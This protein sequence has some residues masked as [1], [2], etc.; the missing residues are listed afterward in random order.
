[1][2]LH[3][4]SS[5]AW[6]RSPT[7]WRGKFTLLPAPL[8]Q[9]HTYGDLTDWFATAPSEE[10]CPASDWRTAACR[11]SCPKTSTRP[12]PS[13][14]G[15]RRKLGLTTYALGDWHEHAADRRPHL[16]RGHARNRPLQ[17]QRF[18][19]GAAGRHR[20]CRGGCRRSKHFAPANS[21]G[22]NGSRGLRCL[23]TSTNWSKSWSR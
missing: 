20:R 4:T 16:V 13:R 8:T 19:A 15:A 6:S 11:A 1:M 7:R 9:R 21:I 17:G 14:P 10:G 5:A 2:P 12:I 3:R 23:P 18:R 22:S